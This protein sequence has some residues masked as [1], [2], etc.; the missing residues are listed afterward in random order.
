MRSRFGQVSPV[1]STKKSVELPAESGQAL[2][3]A[4]SVLVGARS[5]EEARWQ[6]CRLGRGVE[7]VRQRGH[8]ARLPGK[9]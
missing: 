3:D 4:A 5:V 2:R 9:R 1:Y 8:D 7:L 6:S